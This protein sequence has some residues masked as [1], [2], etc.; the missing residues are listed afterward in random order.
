MSQLRLAVIGFGNVGRTLCR[1]TLDVGGKVFAVADSSGVL[2]RRGDGFSHS[3]IE[4]IAKR[5]ADGV[6]LG[7]IEYEGCEHFR[8]PEEMIKGQGGQL[9]EGV[10]CIADCSASGDASK[11]IFQ[12]QKSGC[13]VV[14]ANKKPLTNSYQDFVS[15]T[16]NK[17]LIGFEATCGA[18]LPVIVTLQ[19]MLASG[20]KITKMEGQLSGTLGYILSALQDGGK[21]SDIVR[22]AKS[23]GFTEP[24]P[25]DDLSGMDVA[26]K[27]LI[28][29]RCIG[30]PVEMKDIKIE[31]LYPSEFADISL[32]EFMDRL[33]EL[34]QSMEEKVSAAA[35]QGKR[36]R[37]AAVV[38]PSKPIS[39][40]L[41]AV[42]N[43]A[44]LAALQGTD[45][46]VSFSSKF[47]DTSPTVIRGPGAGLEVT[48]AGVLADAMSILRQ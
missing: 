4:E 1:Q 37:Y 29:A 6:P 7:S 8:S 18:G 17:S 14:L 9:A 38:E 27:A 12:A 20:D 36:L 19:R 2:A 28:L 5:K 46:L 40:G 45:N 30:E 42:D 48:A 41:V 11:Y 34:D 33:P 26:R 23:Q 35:Q 32:D 47:Y 25:R 15:M 3:D 22:E 44:P 24:D 10:S 31:S 16:E 21:F 43:T 39:V 13:P